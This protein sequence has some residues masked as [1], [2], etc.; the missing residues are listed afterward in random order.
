MAT[1]SGSCFN[2]GECKLAGTKF[3]QPMPVGANDVVCKECGKPLS[4]I[5]TKKWGFS[6][7]AVAAIVVVVFVGGIAA[8]GVGLSRYFGGRAKALA[9]QAQVIGANSDRVESVQKRAHPPVT[10]AQ[11]APAGTLAPTPIAS[12]A[13]APASVAT[14]ALAPTPVATVALAPT[15]VATVALAPTPVATAAHTPA[16]VAAVAL[17]P[18][19]IATRALARLPSATTALAPTGNCSALNTSDVR[20]M[21]TAIAEF[22]KSVVLHQWDNAAWYVSAT[23]FAGPAALE[24]GYQNTIE[25]TPTIERING[26]S[27]VV[28]LKFQ[29]DQSPQYCIED[30]YDM[31]YAEQPA[32]RWVIGHGSSLSERYLC[33]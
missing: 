3:A 4:P 29:D 8:G 18:T 33:T 30:R 1:R 16:P 20:G 27:V 2:F 7:G 23:K 6:V 9:A 14:V 22:H 11:P 32:P 13:H 31:Q 15:P 5:S 12:L 21:E 26:C 10:P 19:P 28:M 17:A 24:K 25:S